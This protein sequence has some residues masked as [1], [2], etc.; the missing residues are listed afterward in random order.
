MEMFGHHVSFYWHT[1]REKDVCGC[2]ADYTPFYHYFPQT[3]TIPPDGM[4]HLH[5]VGCPHTNPPEEVLHWNP[6]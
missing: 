5:R 1:E 3:Q 2:L 6:L 4:C